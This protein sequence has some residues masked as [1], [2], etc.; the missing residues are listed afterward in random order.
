MTHQ[1]SCHCGRIAF[2]VAGTVDK[3]LA[4]NCSICLRKGS[5]LWF[6]PRTALTLTTLEEDG[7]TYLFNQHRIKHHFCTVCGIHPYADAQGPDGTQMAA[8][9]IR[10]LEDIDLDAIPVTHWDGRSK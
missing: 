2:Q 10:C 8:I 1:G 9:N 3:A 5:L 7:A 6:V 4:C